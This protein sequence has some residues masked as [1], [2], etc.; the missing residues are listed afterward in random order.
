MIII[1]GPTGVGKSDISLSVAQQTASDIINIDVGQMYT[2]CTIGTAKPD[3][4]H[5][6]VKHYLF[7]YID[8]PR[9]IT[10]TE[11]RTVAAELMQTIH[12]DGHT[13]CFVGGSYF[14]IAS[15][16][17]P[18]LEKTVHEEPLELEYEIS[19]DELHRIDPERAR[20]IN[21]SD[22]YRIGRALAIYYSTGKLPST[23]KPIYQPLEKDAV[24][25]L[26][27]RDRHEL[28]TRINERV[29]I[30]FQQ[31]WVEEVRS[32][33]GTP[34]QPFLM[35]K[36]LKINRLRRYLSSSCAQCRFW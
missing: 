9:D 28:Y 36:K 13:P 19:W 8:T 32:L 16:F 11:Y 3:W 25:I 29:E 5:S 14:Y 15:L 35:K 6:L 7:D 26:L 21:P 23:R 22:G 24:I 31:G 30:M 34:W 17:F 20:S 1:S 2:P 18:P 33:V 12:Q 10:V 27:T 4:Q